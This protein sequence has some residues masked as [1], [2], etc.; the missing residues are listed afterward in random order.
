MTR[1][2]CVSLNFSWKLHEKTRERIQECAR[3]V[4]CYSYT[5]NDGAVAQRLVM[6]C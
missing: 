2:D 1:H 3:N 5:V 4:L 6:G